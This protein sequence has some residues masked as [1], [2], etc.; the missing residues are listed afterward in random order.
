MNKLEKVLCILALSFGVIAVTGACLE[1]S[2]MIQEKDSKI[3]KTM[4]YGGEGISIAS[5]MLASYAYSKD[6]RKKK[7]YKVIY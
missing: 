1:K 5:I 4:F 3:E 6:D 2:A 7:N